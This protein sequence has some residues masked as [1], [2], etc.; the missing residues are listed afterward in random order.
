MWEKYLHTHP[1]P[2]YAERVLNYIRH[3][4]PIGYAGPESSRVHDNW[5]SVYKLRTEV[6]SSLLYDVNRGRKAGPFP[7]KPF[8]NFV[9]SPMGAFYK[10]HSNKVRVI[11]DLSW[12]PEASVNTFI[13][14]SL[15]TLQYIS[16]DDAVKYVKEIGKGTLMSKIDIKDAFKHV[17]VNPDYWHLLGSTWNTIDGDVQFYVDLVLPFGLRSS[18]FLFNQFAIGLEYIMKCKGASIVEHYLDDYFT[19][20]SSKSNECHNNVQIMIDACNETGFEVNPSKVVYPT[21]ELEFLG[22]VIDS[23]AMELR[24]SEQRLQDVYD[25]L[26]KWNDR[27]Q[28]TKRQLLSLIG[29]L[30]FVSR[31]VKPG[32]IFVRRMIELSKHVKHLHFIVKLNKSFRADVKWWLLYLPTWNGISAFQEDKWNDNECVELFTDSSD[33]GIGAVYKTEWFYEVFTSCSKLDIV[34]TSITWRELY[35]LVRA[36]ATWGDKLCN[37]RIIMNCDNIAVMYVVNSGSSKDVNIMNLVRSL[38]Y[39]T[40]HYNLEIRVRHISGRCNILSDALSRLNITKFFN[41]KPDAS[42]V[43]STPV[44]FCYDGDMI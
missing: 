27:K 19:C 38:F 7:Y 41:H 24:I 2:H 30:T 33:V 23:N 16:I 5:P 31:V 42:N 15:C 13:D 21:T 26:I 4:V 12:P 43:M 28:C 11:H 32:R 40:A 36:I 10:K 1:D 9:G 14:D 8:A 44:A 29:K 17:I 37:K 6:E 39:I 22:I 34:N 3:G 35:A 20:G 25:E 18:P